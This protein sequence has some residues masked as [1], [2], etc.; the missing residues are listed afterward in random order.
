MALIIVGGKVYE[1][2]SETAIV[3]GLVLAGGAGG[4]VPTDSRSI[5]DFL[6]DPANMPGVTS[7]HINDRMVEY[8]KL[9]GATLC[10]YNDG[11]HQWLGGKGYT[12]ALNDRIRQWHE[13]GYPN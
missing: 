4:G 3:G 10:T 12:G 11:F 6:S 13:A 2:S 9:Q 7:G 5:N 8:T 1:E